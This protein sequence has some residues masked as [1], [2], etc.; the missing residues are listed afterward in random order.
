MYAMTN[1]LDLFFIF[2]WM[3]GLTK[4]LNFKFATIDVRYGIHGCSNGLVCIS[5]DFV[6]S[7]MLP[8][9]YLLNPLIRKFKK[10]PMCEIKFKA[11]V[12]LLGYGHIGEGYRVVRILNTSNEIYA[13]IF[14]LRLNS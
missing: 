5:S 9:V 6:H 14:G 1:Y 8:H 2:L 13:E 10:L 7:V 3:I 4:C 12:V 11:T